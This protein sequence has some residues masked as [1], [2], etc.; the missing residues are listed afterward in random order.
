MATASR[1]HDLF[2]RVQQL[3]AEMPA[4]EKALLSET[5]QLRFAYTPG[6]GR[7]LMSAVP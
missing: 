2:A 1:G 7:T 5:N 4:V 6:C 3:E